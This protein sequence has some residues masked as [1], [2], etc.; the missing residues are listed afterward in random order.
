MFQVVKIDHLF[1][2]LSPEILPLIARLGFVGALAGFFWRSAMT[3][4]GEGGLSAGAYAQILPKLAEQA[5]YDPGAMPFW[6][7][8]VVGA[9][10]LAEF[11]LPALL[12]VG[13]MTRLAALGMIGFIMVMT[14]TDLFGHGAALGEIASSR[15]IWIS[16]LMVPLLMGGGALSADRWLRG[17]A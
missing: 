6:A 7:H 16:L 15:T 12:L 4:I 13:L 8:L 9:G 2:R 17:R 5:G 11:I 1:S 10:T 3:K 14:L